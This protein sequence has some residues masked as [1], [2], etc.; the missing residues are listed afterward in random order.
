MTGVCELCGRDGMR[1]TDHHLTPRMRH[2]KR[3]KRD[4]TRAE[5]NKTA[6]TCRPCH[7]QIH[8]LFTEKQ[9]EREYNSIERLKAHPDVQKWINW[10][11]KKPFGK[12][13]S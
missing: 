2:N 5:R 7:S 6:D 1:L 4:M 12:E 11:K 9:L 8:S 3:V 13:T 10:V